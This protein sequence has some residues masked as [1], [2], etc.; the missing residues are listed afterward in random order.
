MRAPR[1][2]GI[3]ELLVRGLV[4]KGASR[5]QFMENL[6]ASLL[7]T[8]QPL[9]EDAAIAARDRFRRIPDAFLFGCTERGITEVVAYEVEQTRNLAHGKIIDYVDLY[10]LLDA[11]E[12]HD[13][14]LIRIDRYGQEHEV[15][16]VDC[17][18]KDY[19]AS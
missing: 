5:H 1:S 7:S 14:R 16:L 9:D 17:M 15:D 2:L 10:S 12:T 6:V 13:L 18:F 11:T 3:H 19:A 8:G 4:E